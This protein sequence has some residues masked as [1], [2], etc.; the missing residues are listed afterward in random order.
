[1][2]LRKYLTL[3]RKWM[4]LLILGVLIGGVSA[5]IASYYQTPIYQSTA[6]IFISQP[7]RD[8]LSNL[9]YLSGQQ[10]I[11][12]Y[13]E[14]LVAD[15]V[16]EA[17]YDELG[18]RIW[19]DQISVQQIRDT[20]VLSVTVEDS[21]PDRAA[22]FANTLVVVFGELQYASQTSRYAA[23]KASLETN[24]EEQ[25]Q[26]IDEHVALLTGLA[27]T[28][29]NRLERDRIES[30]LSQYRE[31]YASLLQSYELIRIA[32]A[33]SFSV[34]EL[35]TPAKP[36]RNP[37]RPKTFAN[38]VL[39]AVAGLMIAGSFVFLVEYLDDTIKS[40]DEVIE[41]LKLPIVG[42]IAEMKGEAQA[43]VADNP[44]SP[45]TEAFRTLRTNLEFTEVT[46]PLKTILV[47]S[48][49]PGEGKTTVAANLA[50]VMAQSGKEVVLVD[51]DM[52]RPRMHNYLGIQNRIGLSEYFIDRLSVHDV[53]REWK[54]GEASLKVITS[55]KLPPN[56]AE[57]LGSSMM[58]Q[59]LTELKAL[60][61]VIIIDSP[62]FLVADSL[63]LSA[64]ADGILL[65][66]QPGRT[67]MGAVRTALDQL[68]RSN[69]KILGVVF[70]RIARSHAYQYGYYYN[71]YYYGSDYYSA[72][73]ANGDSI[74]SVNGGKQKR[75]FLS[76][77]KRK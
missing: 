39:G 17:A 58:D 77:I 12:T 48:A 7:P 10:L 55:G 72:D 76:R 69:I 50:L 53:A 34:V 54:L 52:R 11:Q 66:V 18:Y 29:A 71:P 3:L 6:K 38:A 28:D 30:I 43:Y 74:D 5:Y 35:V 64:R 16:L 9:G 42:Y 49:G 67:K 41:T 33:Q 13:T 59:F 65:I 22:E 61:N 37:I 8:E 1:M 36:G 26:L 51:G 47:T 56:P 24:L 14:L 60:A 70:N 62:P 63:V 23:S 4:W 31:I 40:P 27:D 32:E 45:I 75:S 44:R 21:D 15:K 2:E 73:T 25:R 46:S 57:L 20:Q 68:E 19:P